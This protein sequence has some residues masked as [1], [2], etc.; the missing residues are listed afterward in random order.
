VF[1]AICAVGNA[2]FRLQRI[3]YWSMCYLKSVYYWFHYQYFHLGSI[4]IWSTGSHTNVVLNI[5]SGDGC[6]TLVHTQSGVSIGANGLPTPTTID[7]T[8]DLA[9]TAGNSYTFQLEL[10]GGSSLLKSSGNT[11]NGGSYKTNSNCNSTT[12]DLFFIVAMIANSPLPVE[13]KDF[14]VHTMDGQSLL[15]WQTASEQNNLGFEVERSADGQ[16]WDVLGFV[17]GHGT[18]TATS[19]YQFVDERPMA[20]FNY[21]RLRQMDHDGG[22]NYSDTK[23]IKFESMDASTVISPNPVQAGSELLLKGRFEE[24][25]SMILK[26]LQGRVILANS[27][28]EQGPEIRLQLPANVAEGI[29]FLEYFS[30]GKRTAH[31]IMVIE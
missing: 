29:Y 20:G 7:V 14:Q 26:D 6:G 12:D 2:G 15:T 5:Y 1:D 3:D 27:L 23:A 24:V 30:K 10:Q 22:I 18:T 9:F 28:Q 17:A 11:Y 21:Y 25:E 16:Q 13:L 31:K 8:P 19:D 4:T